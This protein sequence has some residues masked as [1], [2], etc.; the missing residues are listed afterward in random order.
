[1][2]VRNSSGNLAI[3]LSPYAIGTFDGGSSLQ[4][5]SIAPFS[6]F[7]LK[8][9]RAAPAA[10]EMGEGRT[11][12]PEPSNDPRPRSLV[13]ALY[14]AGPSATP[15]RSRSRQAGCLRPT[16]RPIGGPHLRYLVLTGPRRGDQRDAH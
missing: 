15:T 6:A 7:G 11:P 8:R 12:R 9:S 10:V 13:G 14:L 3:R 5:G 16:H 2:A 4:I 1:M